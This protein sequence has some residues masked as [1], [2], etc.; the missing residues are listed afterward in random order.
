M[1]KCEQCHSE[2]PLNRHKG[3]MLCVLCLNRNKLLEIQL[4]IE[5]NE[6][7][8]ENKSLKIRSLE[9]HIEALKEENRKLKKQLKEGGE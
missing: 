7:Q 4:Q 3:H 6:Q 2:R 5:G 9:E 1:V 8:I